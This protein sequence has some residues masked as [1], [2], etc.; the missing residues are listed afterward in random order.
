[1]EINPAIIA[2]QRMIVRQY[3]RFLEEQAAEK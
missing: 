1:V 3:Q 2:V